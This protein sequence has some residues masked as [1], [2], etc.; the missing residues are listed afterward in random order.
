MQGEVL[1]QFQSDDEALFNE[2]EQLTVRG[3][4]A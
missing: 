2:L 4:A 3:I 1:F